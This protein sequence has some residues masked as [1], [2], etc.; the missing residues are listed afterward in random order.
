MIWVKPM[1][2]ANKPSVTSIR[3]LVVCEGLPAHGFD[4]FDGRNNVRVELETRAGH[5]AGRPVN[6]NAMAFTTEFVA[7]EAGN[8]ALDFAGAA[9][10]GKR[11][12]RFLYLI[13]S[14]EKAGRREMFICAN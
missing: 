13:W 9:V 2:A 1:P 7:K 11:G 5:D 10:H 14:G 4:G 8:G 3:A 6:G 12:E